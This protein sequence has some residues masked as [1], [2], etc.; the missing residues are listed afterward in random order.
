[1]IYNKTFWKREYKLNNARGE[2]CMK[3][4][5]LVRGLAI[6]YIVIMIFWNYMEYA[7][8]SVLWDDLYIYSIWDAI[9]SNLTTIIIVAVISLIVNLVGDY[10]NKKGY[11]RNIC[12]EDMKRKIRFF[13]KWVNLCFNIILGYIVISAIVYILDIEKSNFSSLVSE[14]SLQKI[15]TTKS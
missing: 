2:K 14:R 7:I 5:K 12:N 3:N 8:Y 1:M 11:T 9:K 15:S 6:L 4:N 13:Y 10:I